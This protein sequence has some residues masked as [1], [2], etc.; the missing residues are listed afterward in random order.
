MRHWKLVSGLGSGGVLLGLML[1]LTPGMGDVDAESLA[2][3]ARV[4]ELRTYTAHPGKLEALH[5]R[6]RDHTNALFVKH[7]MTLIGYWTPVE[8]GADNTLIYLL[9]HENRDAAQAS[10][11]AFKDD[12]EWKQAYADSHKDGPLVE[13]VESRFLNPTDYS[14]LR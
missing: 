13:K 1:T 14:P 7:G 2:E 3:G 6:F 12:P 5:A 4:Y 11:S 10:W 9:A 8:D